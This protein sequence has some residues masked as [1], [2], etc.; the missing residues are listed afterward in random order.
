[1]RASWCGRTRVQTG[2]V[3]RTELARA[4][5]R[6][7]D[8][9]QPDDV[10]LPVGD[11]R[12]VP[13]LRREEVAALAGISVDYVVRLEQARGPQPSVSVLGALARALQLSDAERSELFALADAPEPHPGRISVT[14]RASVRRLLDRLADLPGMVISAKGDVLAWNAMAAALLG[15]WSRYPA[16]ERNIIWLR[17]LGESGRVVL[18]PEQRDASDR[19][20]VA[21]LRTA[22]AHYPDDP[23]LRR[24]VADLRAGSQRFESLWAEAPADAWLSHT[25][26]VRHPDLGLVTLDCESLTVPD[27][28]QT[29]IVYSAEP[30]TEAA[31]QLDLLRVIGTQ[32]MGLIASSPR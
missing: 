14:V 20:S 13:G 15:D 30:G 28:G 21:T 10:G 6:S 31:E 3:D 2:G 7:R 11:R 4:L 9:L 17:F 24:L 26:T 1:M 27:S 25:K 16:R 23:D 32:R 12:R 22:M 18:T 8:R 5:R 29:L 19:H